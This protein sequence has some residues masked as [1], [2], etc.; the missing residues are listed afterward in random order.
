M[1]VLTH[2]QR[3]LVEANPSLA[4][5]IVSQ[6][7]CR[8]PSMATHKFDIM[9]EAWLGVMNAARSFEP[10]RG[11][12]FSTYAW[13]AAAVAIRNYE[14][15]LPPD[16]EALSAPEVV[17]TPGQDLRTND[18]A[19]ALAKAV[20][21]SIQAKVGSR[22]EDI[23]WTAVMCEEPGVDVARRYGISPQRAHQ[24]VDSVSA[25]FQDLTQAM[26][27]EVSV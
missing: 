24:I 12:K 17:N 8:F 25:V 15:T 10:E 9:Q 16:T 26:R 4:D 3:A 1:L 7:I 6:Y 27:A 21:I 18:D 11:V 19:P 5:R 2:A 13:W 14:R 22:D 20:R 23:W